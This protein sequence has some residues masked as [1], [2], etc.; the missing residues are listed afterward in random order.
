MRAPA[1]LLAAALCLATAAQAHGPEGHAPEAHGPEAHGPE[2]HG[3]EAHAPGDQAP[4]DHA[5]TP[6]PVAEDDPGFPTGAIGGPFALVDQDGAPRTEADPDGRPQLLF[7]GYATCPGICSAALPRLAEATAL[8][9]AR[10]VRATP[11]LVTVDPE[12]DRAVDLRAAAAAIHPRLK[13]L[14]GSPERLAAARATFQVEA[15]LLFVSPEYG[16]IYAHGSYVYLLDG[17]GRFLTLMPPIL[18]A[19]RMAEIAAARLAAAA[20]AAP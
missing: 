17:A 13:A 1:T 3:P 10:G 14:T 9:E 6:P 5:T 15:E 16:P 20:S 8:L 19:E 7:F 18:S 2:G 12:V 4:Q 11:V